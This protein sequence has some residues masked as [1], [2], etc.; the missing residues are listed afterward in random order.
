VT[1]HLSS[2]VT[3]AGQHHHTGLTVPF[4][5]CQGSVNKKWQIEGWWVFFICLF[6]CLCMLH[7]P[8]VI[9]HAIAYINSHHGDFLCFTHLFTWYLL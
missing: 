4:P 1:L 9:L 6:V 5:F 7:Y 8:W 3:G 2:T